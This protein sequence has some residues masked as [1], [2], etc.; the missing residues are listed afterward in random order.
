MKYNLPFVI[1]WWFLE[2]CF[3]ELQNFLFASCPLT[4]LE[5]YDWKSEF[6]LMPF[7]LHQGYRHL[8]T[9]AV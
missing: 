8:G 7:F 1:Q 4:S 2:T 6:F 5:V 3:P 9:V